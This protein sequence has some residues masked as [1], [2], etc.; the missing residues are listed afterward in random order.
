MKQD[1]FQTLRNLP[2]NTL[3]KR[4][5]SLL[6]RAAKLLSE[7][8]NTGPVRDEITSQEEAIAQARLYFSYTSS[9]GD[10]EHFDIMYLDSNHRVI[11]TGTL[12]VGTVDACSVYVREVVKSA[13][14]HNAVAVII[15]H[16]HPSGEVSPSRADI[17]ITERI[18][19]GLDTVDIRLLDHIIVGNCASFSFAGSG[20][21]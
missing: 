11:E 20:L 14:A 5:L 17:Q 19:S 3:T 4:E 16:N 7:K 12:H 21:I 13:L 1:I 18:K 15:S 6:T 2:D 8:M 9:M 10:T